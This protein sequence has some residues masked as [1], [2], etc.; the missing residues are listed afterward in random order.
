MQAGTGVHGPL[1]FESNDMGGGALS[2]LSF[3]VLIRGG[4]TGGPHRKG[5]L[6]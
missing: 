1:D 5:G 3:R 2:E 4:R 6:S